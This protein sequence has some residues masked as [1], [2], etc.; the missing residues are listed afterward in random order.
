MTK[1]KTA[2]A[3]TT[4]GDVTAVAAPAPQTEADATAVLNRILAEM[5]GLRTRVE[6][7]EAAKTDLEAQLA[8]ASANALAIANQ[9]PATPSAWVEVRG[10]GPE[11]NVEAKLDAMERSAEDNKELFDRERTRNILLGLPVDDIEFLCETCGTA[12]E[13]QTQKAY[14]QHQKKHELE[15]GRSIGKR[16]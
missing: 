3:N 1:R 14:D 5:Q 10:D 6:A 8:S 13:P 11:R 16:R 12:P 15:A 2:P 7:A 9:R 4:E